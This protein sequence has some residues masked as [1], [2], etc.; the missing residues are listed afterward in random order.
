MKEQTEGIVKNVLKIKCL[1]LMGY[2]GNL[3]IPVKSNNTTMVGSTVSGTTIIK[4]RNI[5]TIFF[6]YSYIII[7]FLFTF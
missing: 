6:I 5:R 1:I 2:L 7:T 3:I 4:D